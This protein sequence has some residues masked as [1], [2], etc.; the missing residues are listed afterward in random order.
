M[1][2]HP[3]PKPPFDEADESEDSPIFKNEQLQD[4]LHQAIIKCPTIPQSVK[5]I[6]KESIDFNVSKI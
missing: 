6:L 5:D 1:S 4:K 2:K 3:K